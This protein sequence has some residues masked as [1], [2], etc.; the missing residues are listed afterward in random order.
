M[1]TKAKQTNGTVSNLNLLHS[2]RNHQQ[3][4]KATTEMGED[5]FKLSDKGLILKIH[6]ELIQFNNKT[7]QIKPNNWI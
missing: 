5:I 3:N 2:K 4:E 1:E 7:K 6:K